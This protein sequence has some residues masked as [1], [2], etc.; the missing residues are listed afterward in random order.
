MTTE[1]LI[2]AN[3]LSRQYGD[4]SA[5]DNVSFTIHR[6]E[7]VTFLGPNGAGKSTLTQIL[8]GVLA[9]SSGNVRLAG[10]DMHEQPLQAKRHLGYLPEQP[11]LYDDCTVDEYLIYCGRLRGITPAQLSTALTACKQTCGLA[12]TGKRLLSNLSKG[13]RQ[14]VGIAQAIIHQPDVIILDEPSSGVDPN[15]M[16]EIRELIRSLGTGHA[17]ILSTHMLAEAQDISDRILIMHTGHLV[18]DQAL[19]SL[20]EPLEQT[21]LNL[22]GKSSHGSAAA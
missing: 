4:R 13:Y 22:T 2:E 14:R 5:V 3:A 9:P 12:D 20:T 17:V 8:S 11:P 21:Y 15:Q 1:T 7:I 19:T 6:G 16:I 18:F 10:Y